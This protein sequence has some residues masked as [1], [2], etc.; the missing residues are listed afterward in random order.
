MLIRG[1]AIK[2]LA[3]IGNSILVALFTAIKLNRSSLFAP[4]APESDKS[5]VESDALAKGGEPISSWQLILE[6]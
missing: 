4:R 6:F 3:A 5:P 1:R 2:R